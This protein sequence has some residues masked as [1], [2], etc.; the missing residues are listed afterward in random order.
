MAGTVALSLDDEAVT[1]LARWGAKRT[2]PQWPA[3]LRGIPPESV[4][5]RMQ[6]GD[7]IDISGS[8]FPPMVLRPSI[9][10]DGRLDLAARVEAKHFAAVLNV[11]APFINRIVAQVLNERLDTARRDLAEQGLHLRLLSV[12]TGEGILTLTAAIDP[13]APHETP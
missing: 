8:G 9:S 10:A 12:H 11:A 3:L 13:D 4:T 7:R 5:A 1:T 2:H 6:P